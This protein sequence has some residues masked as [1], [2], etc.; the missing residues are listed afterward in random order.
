[1]VAMKLPRRRFL[2]LAAAAAAAD[3]RVIGSREAQ[4]FIRRGQC[5]FIVPFSL[6]ARQT[7]T[8]ARLMGS[9]A[10]WSDFGQ[11]IRH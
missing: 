9:I 8:I 10:V 4:S 6:P 2:H 3:S 5:G 11:A 7:D 1:M